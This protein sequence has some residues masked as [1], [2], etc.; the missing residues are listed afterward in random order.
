MQRIFRGGFLNR[1]Q[2]GRAWQSNRDRKVARTKPRPRC[3]ETRKLV[4]QW[5]RTTNRSDGIGEQGAGVRRWY[6]TPCRFGQVV[7]G[8]A[9][10]VILERVASMDYLAKGGG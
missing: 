5:Q 9:E 6:G 7:V 1:R 4:K 3:G 8:G 2:R 10:H